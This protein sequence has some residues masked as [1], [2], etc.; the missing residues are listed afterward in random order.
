MEQRAHAP[1]AAGCDA[2]R[3]IAK[4]GPR[5]ACDC[6][7]IE[8]DCHQ[9]IGQKALEGH[10]HA[11]RL[12]GNDDR[13]RARRHS[14]VR[15]GGCGRVAS[16]AQRKPTAWHQES[17]VVS[18]MASAA[19]DLAQVDGVASWDARV[20]RG[21]M[22]RGPRRMHSGHKPPE[23][24]EWLVLAASDGRPV[25]GYGGSLCARERSVLQQET[26]HVDRLAL[27]VGLDEECAAERRR[28]GRPCVQQLPTRVV[29]HVEATGAHS[30]GELA[31]EEEVDAALTAHVRV[32]LRFR[33][34]PL[35]LVHVA[36]IG[37]E[38]LTGVEVVDVGSHE[39]QI[40]ALPLLSR[41]ASHKALA[42]AQRR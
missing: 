39:E 2:G 1:L 28:V 14:V 13:N 27:E 6:C 34:A 26:G 31:T 38:A 5:I 25:R 42:T 41:P 17:G 40:V 33:R 24:A 20:A 32:Q 30:R 10:A 4:S 7:L 36:R 9:L 37:L 11:P 29:A 21:T 22:I 18:S 15:T 12:I 3:H 35:A 16:W 19:G 8:G 23:V